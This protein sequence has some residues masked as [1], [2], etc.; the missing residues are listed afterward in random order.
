[1][2]A[3]VALAAAKKVV[4]KAAPSGGR[5]P[6]RGSPLLRWVVVG[7]G[8]FA[9]MGLLPILV[10]GG[11]GNP[12]PELF[13]PVAKTCP[14]PPGGG[15]SAPA[16]PAVVPDGASDGAFT[17]VGW[18][19]DFLSRLG[20]GDAEGARRA[21]L[22]WMR[23]EGGHF[24]N[25][26]RFNPLNTTMEAPGA[27]SVNPIGVKSYPD[28]ETGMGA[29]L[30][31]IRV[32]NFGYPAIVAALV[33][34]DGAGA[35]DAVDASKWG[36]HDPLLQRVYDGLSPAD[37]EGDGT[38]TPGEPG[39]GPRPS[40][41]AG[42]AVSADEAAILNHP[43]VRMSSDARADL[44]RGGVVDPRILGAVKW[45]ADH[46]AVQVEVF[47]QGHSRCAGGVAGENSDGTCRT[48]DSNHF[49]GRAVDLGMIGPIGSEPSYVTSGN[50]WARE[51]VDG[52]LATP[53]YFRLTELGQPFYDRTEGNLYVFT[54]DHGD[55]LHLGID[56]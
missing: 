29:T 30:E 7:G 46:W 42:G 11:I 3:P 43:N 15:G 51:A 9:A 21:T 25:G 37:Y 18:L 4:A 52:I 14:R 53:G 39:A 44:E 34:G 33:A 35:V 38:G 47:K 12:P 19:R 41:G 24:V 23:A 36:T 8:G 45:I 1:V 16:G 40:C 13:E 5:G 50:R 48:G 31:T 55:H 22:A 26:A 27:T 10:V 56:A 17:E 49:Y 32:D 20:A 28:Y 2:V 6:R 54:A